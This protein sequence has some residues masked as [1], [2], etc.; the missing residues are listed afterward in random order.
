MSRNREQL[1]SDRGVKLGR[2]SNNEDSK[3]A[4]L[5]FLKKS[6]QFDYCYQWD[7]AGFPIL[8][9]PEDIVAFQEILFRCQPTVITET[10]V[11]WG[12]SIALGA[13]L[14]SL[15]EPTGK[16]LG[17]DKHLDSTLKVRS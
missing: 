10:G 3:T 14:M 9:M 11:A 12:G 17:I 13:S 16:V 15:Y 8:N 1:E 4:S 6:Y 2:Q 5:N 7:W